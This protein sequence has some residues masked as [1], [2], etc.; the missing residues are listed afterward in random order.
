M[1]KLFESVLIRPPSM[2][3]AHC[4]SSNPDKNNIDFQL[5]KTQHRSYVSILKENNI[6]VCD[7]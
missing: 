1:D 7:H 2:S 4:V 6:R 3:Y 5:A